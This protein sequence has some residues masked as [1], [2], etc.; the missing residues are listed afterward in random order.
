MERDRIEAEVRR[1]APWRCRFE[2]GEVATDIAATNE[3]GALRSVR[4]P[5][6]A[7]AALVGRTVLDAGCNEGGYSFAALD[8]GAL[9]VT[10]FDAALS[11]IE[12]ARFVASVRGDDNVEFHVASCGE[13][14][15]RSRTPVDYVFLCGVLADFPD[16]QPILH[17]LSRLASRGVFVTSPLAGGAHGYTTRGA[18]A[19]PN[20][21][22]T[23]LHEF[24]PYGLF[25]Q[26]IAER[27]TRKPD[28][29]WG[30]CSLL[31]KR[32]ALLAGDANE[33][34]DLLPRAEPAL[35]M[36]VVPDDDASTRERIGIGIC[37]YNWSEQSLDLEAEVT[38]ETE[39]GERGSSE[40]ALVEL[41]P[42]LADVD[43]SSSESTTLPLQFDVA[44][45]ETLA[46]HVTMRD[47]STG[48]NVARRSTRVSR[49]SLSPPE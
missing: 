37:V 20:S 16:P 31:L 47:R 19:V 38:T 10:G 18:A 23:L 7:R 45:G 46:V 3:A 24:A 48:R 21:A 43:G 42:R 17:G 44:S 26:Y 9:S 30:E 28:E 11:N 40:R 22:K 8:Y 25:P 14:L 2:L 1:L 36:H 33:P 34:D 41:G 32:S 12:K 13:W 27:R 35:E 39:A 15:Q 49:P 4:L 29:L 6:V 5:N